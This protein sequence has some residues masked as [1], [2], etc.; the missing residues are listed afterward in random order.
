[1][2]NGQG[3]V[4]LLNHRLGQASDIPLLFDAAGRNVEIDTP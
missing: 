4:E 2:L 1:M 3:D